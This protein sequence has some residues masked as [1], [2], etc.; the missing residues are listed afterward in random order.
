MWTGVETPELKA[1]KLRYEEKFGYNPDKEVSVYYA[2]YC[3]QEY[4][5]DIEECIRTGK[6]IATLC[7]ERLD[8]D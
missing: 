7:D 5:D 2:D 3:T 8:F 1:A 4:I 6:D